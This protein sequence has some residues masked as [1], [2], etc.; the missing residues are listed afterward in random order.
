M[1][2]LD[3]T[4]LI[5]YFEGV[6]STRTFLEQHDTEA[7]VI[8]APAYA[9]ALLGEGNGPDGDVEG[10]REAL[11]WAEVYGVDERTAVTA[12]EIADEIGPE[13]PFL[14]GMDGLELASHGN[15]HQ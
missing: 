4:V 8:P 3:A 9:E 13:G 10:V 5:D 11:S 12:A 7:Y 1:R 15:L 6:D 2:D 14:T